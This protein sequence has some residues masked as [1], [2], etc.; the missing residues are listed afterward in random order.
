MPHTFLFALLAMVTVNF[1]TPTVWAKRT[2]G[3]QSRLTNNQKQ[4]AAL[5]PHQACMA[6]CTGSTAQ[7]LYPCWQNCARFLTELD[8]DEKV[9]CASVTD[10]ARR[11][12]CQKFQP[13]TQSAELQPQPEVQAGAAQ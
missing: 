8:Q 7:V 3:V 9:R 13:K 6:N 11:A 1:A 2:D 4:G 10:P 5:T 12:L